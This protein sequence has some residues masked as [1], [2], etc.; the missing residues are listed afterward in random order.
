MIPRLLAPCCSLKGVRSQE[1]GMMF[2]PCFRIVFQRFSDVFPTPTTWEMMGRIHQAHHGMHTRTNAA[3]PST[4]THI[5]WRTRTH[6]HAHNMALHGMHTCTNRVDLECAP[7]H[8]HM[9]PGTTWK[10]Q[11]A[12]QDL[13]DLQEGAPE[14]CQGKP[15][16]GSS[17]LIRPTVSN[18]IKNCCRRALAII[19][20][21]VGLVPNAF[22]ECIKPLSPKNT[23]RGGLKFCTGAGL[24]R[25]SR[26]R[27][28]AALNFTQRGIS[29]FWLGA[30]WGKM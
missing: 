30:G 16:W 12:S 28:M 7:W 25:R 21:R 5:T 17:G 23:Q 14:P 26:G 4:H 11:D 2:S 24:R 19:C 20:D 6:K 3:Q 1:T 22:C 29:K 27:P 18:T 10:Y 15:R 8:A 13:K 9:A